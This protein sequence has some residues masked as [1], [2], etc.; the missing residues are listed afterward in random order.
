VKRTSC[1]VTTLAVL[2]LLNLGW[3]SV[4][5]Q[6]VSVRVDRWLALRQISGNVTYLKQGAAPRSA[7]SGDRL[8][9]VGDGVS[10]GKNS[11]TRLEVDTGVG[12]VNVAENTQ[13]KVGWLKVA[14]DNGRI[15]RLD[16]IKGQVRLQV[17]RF[18][19]RGSNLEIKTP[20]GISAVRGTQFGI[21]I[22]P[23]G[24]TGLATRE[25]KVVMTAQ[26]KTVA[27]PAGF[28][29]LTIPGE[30]PLPA[31]PLKDDTTLNYR[32][33]RELVGNNRQIRFIGQVDPVNTVFL[34]EAPQTTDRNGRFE[35]L[36]PATLAPSL[37]VTVVTPLGR[38]QDHPLKIRL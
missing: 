35:L 17:R 20:A 23:D 16:V 22:Q 10:T 36:L 28:Q 11:T 6:P 21:G 7:K 26:G 19:H 4:A 5:Q 1:F 32:I 25:G 2:S 33:E 31:V 34:G 8:Q 24:K 29:N 38:R 27:V 9:T 13:I 37:K 14:P 3:Q 18:T 15:T 30:P 12:F